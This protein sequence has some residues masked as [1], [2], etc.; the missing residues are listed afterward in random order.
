MRFSKRSLQ[1]EIL[2]DNR[3]SPGV[4]LE[5]VR[6]FEAAKGQSVMHTPGGTF[7]EEGTLTCCHCAR[8]YHINRQ[9]TR[10]REYCAK[11]DAYVCDDPICQTCRPMAAVFA[12]A[13]A[14]QTKL[15]A[16]PDHPEVQQSLIMLT[17]SWKWAS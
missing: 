17:D 6:A 11:C 3:E 15:D 8:T 10:P 1:G 9:R 13:A 14:L 5:M 12:Q 16:Q 2:I 4:P 7:W